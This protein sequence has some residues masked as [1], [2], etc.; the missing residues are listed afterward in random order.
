MD[1]IFHAFCDW[2][3][4]IWGMFLALATHLIGAGGPIL[5]FFLILNVVDFYYGR[6]KAKATNT[7]SS[8]VGADGIRK[9]VS[10][11]VVIGIA[12]YV[13]HILGSL[14]GPQLGVDLSW[15]H[16][17]GWF[18]LAV[19]IINELTSII[20]NLIVLGYDPPAI[21]VKGLAVAR[22]VVDAAGNKIIPNLDQK[23]PSEDE[24]KS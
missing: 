15:L 22:T 19:Y 8:K 10:Y 14:L 11:W 16:L 1:K 17:I 9:K 4:L 13:A 20:E 6:Q 24:K 5:F 12:F 7:L 3:N 2:A 18:T 23:G 21:L